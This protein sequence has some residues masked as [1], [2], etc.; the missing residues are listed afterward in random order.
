M[1]FDKNK[2]LKLL[3]QRKSLEKE[4]NLLQDYNKAKSDELICYRILIV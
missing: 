3:N 4:G 2:Y 1:K